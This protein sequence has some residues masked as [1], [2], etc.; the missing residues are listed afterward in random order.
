[1]LYQKIHYE[2]GLFKN[3]QHILWKLCCANIAL[4]FTSL[5]EIK[6]TRNWCNFLA[7]KTCTIALEEQVLG[8]DPL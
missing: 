2:E 5:A 1:M 8:I 4:G 3:D 6:I 7:K